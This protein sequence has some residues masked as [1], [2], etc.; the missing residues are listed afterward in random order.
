MAR[1]QRAKSASAKRP[2]KTSAADWFRTQLTGEV[3]F[4]PATR[5]KL[6]RFERE[7]G[8][9]P[10]QVLVD[11]WLVHNERNVCFGGN[12]FLSV[13]EAVEAAKIGRDSRSEWRETWTPF[14]QDGM[15]GIVVA[16][17]ETGRV[18]F[19][20]SEGQPTKVVAASVREYLEDAG[21]FAIPSPEDA[22]LA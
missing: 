6:A 5:A 7:L 22:E 20:P 12:E 10:P 9:P 17:G 3:R 11:M 19:L 15:G 4:R 2:T 18:L 13:A 21:V 8:R 16:D 1:K 14:A